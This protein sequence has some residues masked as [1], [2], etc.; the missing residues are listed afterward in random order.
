MSAKNTK[1][2]IRPQ[3][4]IYSFYIIDVDKEMCLQRMRLFHFVT[5]TLTKVLH[6]A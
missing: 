3:Q 5:R 2:Y 4:A 6:N 1:D